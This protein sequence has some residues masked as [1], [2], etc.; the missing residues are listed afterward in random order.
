MFVESVDLQAPGEVALDLG[1]D[2]AN[3]EQQGMKLY[4]K[5]VKFENTGTI[6]TFNINTVRAGDPVHIRDEIT[7]LVGKYYVKSGTHTVSDQ[8]ASMSLTV[9]IEDA[10]PEAY[11]ARAQTKASSTGSL[12]G[13]TGVGQVAAPSGRNWT[14]MGG[15]IS[16]P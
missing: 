12:L 14:I 11:E 15:S 10:L 9:N 1:N 4:K 3:A 2:R 7:G 8:E 13:G 16:I 6:T 5:L